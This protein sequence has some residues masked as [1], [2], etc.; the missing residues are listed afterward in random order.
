MATESMISTITVDSARSESACIAPEPGG[1]CRLKG[2]SARDA[3]ERVNDF[4]TVQV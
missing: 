2:A 1:K 3:T 4:E